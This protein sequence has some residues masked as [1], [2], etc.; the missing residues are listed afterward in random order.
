MTTG[1]ESIFSRSAGRFGTQVRE[2]SGR[3]PRPRGIPL[4]ECPSAAARLLPLF[5]CRSH[6]SPAA[7]DALGVVR[8][9]KAIR[10]QN[11]AGGVYCAAI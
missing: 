2:T 5:R 7:S 3:V 9:L 8:R 1:A 4:R 11:Q 10:H 6:P